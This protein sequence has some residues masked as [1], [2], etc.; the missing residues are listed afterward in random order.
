MEV[1]SSP[2]LVCCFVS[3]SRQCFCFTM[4]FHV[5]GYKFVSP[6]RAPVKSIFGLV[7][8]EDKINNLISEE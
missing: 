4:I 8:S 1:F 2:Y 3:L 7:S 6:I 5:F